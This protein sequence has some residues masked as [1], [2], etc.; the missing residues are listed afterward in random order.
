MSPNAKSHDARKSQAVLRFAQD[1]FSKSPDWTAFY[2]E[3]LGIRGMIHRVFPDTAAV[4]EFK[5]SEE[6][7]EIQRMLVKLRKKGPVP[8]NPDDPTRVIMVRLPRSL[9]E[10]LRDEA[11]ARRTS[12]N[13]LC[14]SKLLQWIDD[15][16]VPTASE[17]DPGDV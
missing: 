3:V 11:F 7:R 4:A 2:R 12:I 16:M 10:A 9:H 8:K 15:E 14:I 13:K 17:D 5:Q 1:L 6:Y